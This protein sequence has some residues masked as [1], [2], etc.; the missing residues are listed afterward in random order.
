MP[1][2][3]RYC[4]FQNCVCCIDHFEM[5]KF[6]WGMVS[7]S[8]RGGFVDFFF[9]VEILFLYCHK[10]IDSLAVLGILI[11]EP[12]AFLAPVVSRAPMGALINKFW[13]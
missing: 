4:G 3:I 10:S 6:F 11:S 8:L 5:L 13:P 2:D 7:F 12:F 9:F 1:Q